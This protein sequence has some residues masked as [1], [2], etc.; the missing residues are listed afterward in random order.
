MNNAPDC[1]QACCHIVTF[2]Y[3]YASRLRDDILYYPFKP[4]VWSRRI[5]LGRAEWESES[6]GNGS[7]ADALGRFS[8]EEGEELKTSGK[9]SPTDGFGRAG[10]AAD[11]MELEGGW[12]G[13]AEGGVFG[14]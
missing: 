9:G 8:W 11:G 5:C 3:I 1:F 4:T 2:C 14:A 6:G 12:L 7:P 13:I 10:G